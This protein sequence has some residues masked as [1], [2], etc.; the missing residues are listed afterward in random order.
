LAANEQI[1]CSFV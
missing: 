1:F